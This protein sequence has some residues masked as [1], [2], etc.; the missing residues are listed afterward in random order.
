[1]QRKRN[2]LLDTLALEHTCA[3]CG[4]GRAEKCS[5]TRRRRAEDGGG[6]RVV[7]AAPHIGRLRKA[8]RYGA[9]A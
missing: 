6:W 5:T 1:M 9:K 8:A 7:D 3:T 2:Q 4:A